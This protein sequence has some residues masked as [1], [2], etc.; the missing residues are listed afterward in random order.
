[1]SKAL[2]TSKIREIGKALPAAGYVELDDQADA[3]GLCRSTTWAIL[4]ANHK[5]SGLTA[6][7]IHRMLESRRLPG[8]VRSKV[9]EYVEEKLSGRYGHNAKQLHHF[10]QRLGDLQVSGAVRIGLRVAVTKKHKTTQ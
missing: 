6:A 5:H 8:S 3:L 7:V 2:Q 4:Q 9:L 10:S 1:M